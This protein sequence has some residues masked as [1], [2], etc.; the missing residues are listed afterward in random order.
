M[1]L[2]AAPP[3]EL[4]ASTD[5]PHDVAAEMA[6][7]GDVL[8]SP[9]FIREL[10]LHGSDFYEPKHGTIW[11]TITALH[12]ER[13]P[14]SAASVLAALS[15]AGELQR[16]GGGN[17]LHDLI[18]SAQ[19]AP[20]YHAERIIEMSRRRQL[21]TAGKRI[22][23]EAL[24]GHQSDET[25][26]RA[27]SGLH[28]IRA[29][30]DDVDTLLNLD[31]FVNQP[32]PAEEWVIPNLLAKGERLVL[33]GTEG[34]GKSTL[35]RQIAVAAAAGVDPFTG[36]FIAPQKVLLI[37]VENP[38]RIM[39]NRFG[40]LLG[41]A[42]HANPKFNPNN[43]FIDRKPEGLNLANPGDRRYLQRRIELTNPDLL[44]IGPAYK[45]F[46]QTAKTGYEELAQQVTGTLD[47]LRAETTC[48]LI[49]E[50]HSGHKDAA[51]RVREVRPTGS[52]LW[53]RW[54]EFGYGIRAVPNDE[55]E[56][57]E[58]RRLVDVVAWR[59]P[60]DERPWPQ[61]LERGNNGWPWMNARPY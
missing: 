20:G 38:K 29:F 40:D 54:P 3:L 52:S 44:V 1:T 21:V 48:A 5:V 61:Q 59:G 47:L 56:N 7:L 35:I 13:R 55:D 11:D 9:G 45:M 30:T 41:A 22:V 26:D 36:T 16:V 24:T 50:H 42:R 57:A 32:L 43:L 25:L 4:E 49:L 60:R 10:T 27:I 2:R 17:Y 14:V 8:E 12:R 19:S 18:A 51:A 34:L 39:V 33:T 53:L 31:E 15:D 23:T 28:G 37:D 58:Y 6:V 46:L